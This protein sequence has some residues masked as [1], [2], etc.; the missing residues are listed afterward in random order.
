MLM[1]CNGSATD[2]PSQ[3]PELASMFCTIDSYDN[4]GE[5]SNY[6]AAM[7]EATTKGGTLSVIATG[8]D[9]GIFSINR[10]LFESFLADGTT[11]FFYGPGVSQGHSEAVRAVDG[12]KKGVQYTIP[13]DENLQKVQNG[14]I[15][16]LTPREKQLRHCVIVAEEGADKGVIEKT[17]KEMPNYFE[18]YNTIV[19]FVDEEEFI[20][21]HSSMPHGGFVIRTGF[22]GAER[23]PETMEF[24]LKLAKNPEFTASAM[25][26]YAR[27]AKRMYDNGDRGAK[28]VFDIA[29]ALLSPKS[30]SELVKELL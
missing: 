11:N 26:P 6:F 25:L 9:P 10:V 29:P 17:I 7:N 23:N 21:N 4:H 15:L 1:L 2:L 18:P 28:T 8:W 16:D 22:T 24:S 20:K 27:A 13:V 19:D 3:G 30:H 5:M 14:E 12:V